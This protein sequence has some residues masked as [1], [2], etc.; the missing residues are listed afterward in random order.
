MSSNEIHA[1]SNEDD[2]NDLEERLKIELQ[3]RARVLNLELGE[4]VRV[5]DTEDTDLDVAARR[6]RGR[7]GGLNVVERT[8][9]GGSA[10]VRVEMVLRRCGVRRS[11]GGGPVEDG[12]RA[13]GEE[14]VV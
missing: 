6:E 12:G 10:G 9:S 1:I 2:K 14:G 5:E 4:D 8:T 11:R 7:E 3:R 13:A